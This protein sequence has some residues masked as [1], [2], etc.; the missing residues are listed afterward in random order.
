MEKKRIIG[1]V[2]A[3]STVLVLA[4]C[5]KER[6]LN[7][8][9]PGTPIV[10]GASGSWYNGLFT[11]TEYS[12]VDESG[13]A[14]SKNSEYERL[15]WKAGY[16][17]LRILCEAAENGPSADYKLTGTPSV[18][19][20][21][22]L[23]KME[24]LAPNGLQWGTGD[25]YFYAMY[26]IPGMKSNYDFGTET[27]VS[28][29]NVS[30]TSTTVSGSAPTAR[31]TGVVPAVQKVVKVGNEY[32]SNMN[33]AYLYAATLVKEDDV[34]TS[35]TLSFN[36]LVTMLEF[37]LKRVA[38]DPIAANLTKV[39][40]SSEGGSLS[41]TFVADLSLDAS[42]NAQADI[43]VSGTTG[44]TITINLPTEEGQSVPGV[45]LSDTPL[46]INFL[47]LPLS[48]TN[49]KLTL[50]FGSG[51]TVTRSLT[52]KDSSLETASNPEGWVTAPACKKVYFS[53]LGVPYSIG[54]DYTLD[55]TGGSLIAP[56]PKSGG[57]VTYGVTSYRTSRVDSSVKEA[58]S[59]KATF[60][61][62]GETWG[63]I[64][65]WLTFTTQGPGSIAAT[66]YPA[67]VANNNVPAEWEGETDVIE[68]SMASARDL[69]CYDIY[70]NYTGGTEGSAPYNTANCYVV[71]APGWY[72]FPCVYGN[73]IKNGATNSAAY[74]GPSSGGS[75][76]TNGF[77]NHAG[78]RITNP[79][80]KNNSVTVNGVSLVWEDVQG[81]VS[82]VAYSNDYIY[83][84]I[85]PNKIFEGNILIAA[86]SGSTTVWSWHIWVIDQPEVR[87]VTKNVYSHPTN[88]K[89]IVYPNKM[90][91][92][93][94]GF[95]DGVA[96]GSRARYQ[97]IKFTQEE[98]GLEKIVALSQFGDSYNCTYYQWGRK[99]PMIPGLISNAA[100]EP[101]LK[102]VYNINGGRVNETVATSW[103]SV[104]TSIQN[105]FTFYPGLGNSDQDN[106][107]STRY[108]NLWNTN[109]RAAASGLGTDQVVVKTIYDP[110]P[111]GFKVPNRN[112]F[113]GFT[114]TGDN[115]S[116]GGS[117]MFSQLSAYLPETVNALMGYNF[118]LNP[119]RPGD[120]TIFFHLTGS[121]HPW[122][123]K[124]YGVTQFGDITTATPGQTTLN[125]VA[126]SYFTLA[127]D[128]VEPLANQRR[129][130]GFPV[131][132]VAE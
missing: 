30:M 3:L 102:T 129:A 69:S 108:D 41:G 33:Y 132:A 90:L 88:N 82:N 49:L 104:A 45:V 118:Y 83:F 51:D 119:S 19:A 95:C 39:E 40:L 10:F 8:R 24:C 87:L 91:P 111:P 79:W 122:T 124:L 58:V 78:T 29:S 65:S 101:T 54:W 86:K 47:T 92:M 93:N 123:G 116:G 18:S 52:L 106:W 60:S 76:M 7:H 70:G 67:T 117:A 26:P 112:A 96:G 12:G 48:H 5:T 31:I 94:L 64:P 81:L 99:D 21:K 113:T 121:R 120:G 97:W 114:K 56:L 53:N 25:H 73:G 27:T 61:S 46:K 62:D 130:Y 32:K 28:S 22:S 36:P 131:R 17:Q 59:W 11:R 68:D 34:E 89:S 77:L 98:S 74:T 37:T 100:D 14:V 35:V 109:V 44:N 80:I 127:N 4:G 105:P 66:N 55:V 75:L 16:D 43:A 71:S 128:H 38:D 110:C 42:G 13:N 72:R 9:E 50:Y 2:I 15:D 125:G 57:S 63:P 84:R 115:I 20:Q 103:T 1:A 107:C 23:A 6:T 126:V 85:D